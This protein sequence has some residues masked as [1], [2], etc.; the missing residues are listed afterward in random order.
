MR[1]TNQQQNEFFQSWKDKHLKKEEI[2]IELQAL[3]FTDFETE[4]LITLF[5][6]KLRAERTS[7]G[8]IFSAVG[9]FIGFAG[10]V[11]AMLNFMPD[12]HWFFL[13]VLTSIGVC[14]VFTGLYFIF[15]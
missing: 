11:L 14:L 1:L 12:L 5:Y 6:K 7:K 10:C 13:Y 2:L 3:R 4:E 9:A 8:A 15:E